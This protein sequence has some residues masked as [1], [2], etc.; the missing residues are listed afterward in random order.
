MIK[1]SPILFFVILLP[2]QLLANPQLPEQLSPEQPQTTNTED[3]QK[4]KVS[5][6]SLYQ[7]SQASGLGYGILAN[8]Q[9]N[10]GFDIAFGAITSGNLESNSDSTITDSYQGA[11]LGL[12]INKQYNQDISLHFSGGINYLLATEHDLLFKQDDVSPYLKLGVNY[13][14]SEQIS[15]ELGQLSQFSLGQLDNHHSTYLAFNWKFGSSSKPKLS[16]DNVKQPQIKIIRKKTNNNSELKQPT[17][18]H[19]QLG[20]FSRKE[21]AQRHIANLIEA[22]HIKPFEAFSVIYH[23]DYYRVVSKGF[24]DRIKAIEERKR[25]S[26][27]VSAIVIFIEQ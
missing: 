9:L 8:Y 5:A 26:L 20:A 1:S 18:W 22:K 15:L 25:L 4:W 27:K 21:N 24:N 14:L 7:Q 3:G 6:I 16:I 10:N 2:S 13:S 19:V 17:P 12:G 11:L 23:K